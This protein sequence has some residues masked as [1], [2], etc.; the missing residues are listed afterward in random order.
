[1][2]IQ[3]LGGGG[4]LRNFSPEVGMFAGWRVRDEHTRATIAGLIKAD[5]ERTVP[6]LQAVEG[7]PAR[8]S[9]LAACSFG[10][11]TFLRPSSFIRREQTRF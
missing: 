5:E 4:V 1:M 2:Q 6:A 9:R 3:Y 8:L 11:L 7:R 10:F